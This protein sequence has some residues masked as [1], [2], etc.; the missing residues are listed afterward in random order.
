MMPRRLNVI[1]KN[2]TTFRRRLSWTREVLV[3]KLRLLGCS[4]TPDVLA[5]IESQRC[6]VTNTHI[7]F[8]SQVFCVSVE[9]LFPSKPDAD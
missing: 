7:F 1:G 9:K 4:I 2:V 3:A 6:I 8:L 5:K